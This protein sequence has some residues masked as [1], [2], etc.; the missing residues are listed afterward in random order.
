[1]ASRYASGQPILAG[2]VSMGLVLTVLPGG[3]MRR[4]MLLGLALGGVHVLAVNPLLG[5]RIL[6]LVGLVF[7]PLAQRFQRGWSLGVANEVTP[8]CPGKNESSRPFI[9]PRQARRIVA[10]G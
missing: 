3:D 4:R 2:T 6:A 1:M 7:G 9:L 8:L 10:G 5:L